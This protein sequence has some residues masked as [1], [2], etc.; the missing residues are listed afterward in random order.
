M[1]QRYYDTLTL[2]MNMY[3][4]IVPYSIFQ[5]NAKEMKEMKL[6]RLSLKVQNYF[7]IY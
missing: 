4:V 1:F 2:N 5:P 3:T 6:Q 7:E